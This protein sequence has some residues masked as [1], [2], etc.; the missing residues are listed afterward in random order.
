MII[1][2][3]DNIPGPNKL[4]Y[5]D[6]TKTGYYG[7]TTAAELITGDALASQIGL[8]AGTSQYNDAGWEKFFVGAD[9]DCN[10]DNINKILYIA[11]KTFRYNLSWDNIN[12]VNAVYGSRIIIIGGNAYKVRLLRGSRS[13]LIQTH[14][15]TCSDNFGC[16]SEWNDLL[17]R[18]H[19][20][21]PNCSDPTVGMPGGNETFR[22]GGP[23]VGTNWNNYSDAD[24]QVYYLV[25]YGTYCWCQETDT[26]SSSRCV[27]RGGNGV[28]YYNTYSSS[29]LHDGL[30]WLP[31]LEL[32]TPVP[33]SSASLGDYTEGGYY[34]HNDGTYAYICSVNDTEAE[35]G[36]Y[37]Y[38]VSGADSETDGYQNTLDLISDSQPHPAA[39]WCHD[40]TDGGYTDWYLPS[41][42]ELDDLYNNKNYTN[43]VSTTHHWSSMNHSSTHAHLQYFNDGNQN[44]YFK[45]LSCKVRAIRKLVL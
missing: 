20:D 25:G 31:C 19:T 15:I 18:V 41:K 43:I 9:A 23:Q 21:V 16:N 37:N 45:T 42:N 3:N 36:G 2:K 10:P 44:V 11:K 38:K 40:K 13:D 33:F 4:T 34:Y 14:D 24:L 39:Q 6:T 22:H 17:Y 35:W 29:Y 27:S 5:D 12:T 8:T 7:H 30:G 32:V 26:L 1:E 28:A